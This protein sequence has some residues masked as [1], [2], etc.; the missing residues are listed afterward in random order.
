LSPKAGDNQ[1]LRQLLALHQ[2]LA[3][4]YL[5]PADME[6]ARKEIGLLEKNLQE[7]QAAARESSAKAP[8]TKLPRKLLISAP[9]GLLEQAGAGKIS[10]EQFTKGVYMEELNFSKPNAASPASGAY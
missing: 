2:K 3:Q 8:E 4:A 6:K 10:F 9:K 5:S 7:R 1:T